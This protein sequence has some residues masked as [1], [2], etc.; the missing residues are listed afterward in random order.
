MTMTMRRYDTT[1]IPGGVLG[2]IS[3]LSDREIPSVGGHSLLHTRLAGT[4]C[5]DMKWAAADTD[6]AGFPSDDLQVSS[7]S[8]RP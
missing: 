8:K 6:F 2:H 7:P 5:W 4:R 1:L 3:D